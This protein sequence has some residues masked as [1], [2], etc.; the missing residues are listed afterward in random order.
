MRRVTKMTCDRCGDP[1]GDYI[2]DGC[3]ERCA[4]DDLDAAELL[5]DDLDRWTGEEPNAWEAT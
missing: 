2:V 5:R 4:N 3:C 1:L